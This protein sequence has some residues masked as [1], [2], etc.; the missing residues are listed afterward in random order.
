MARVRPQRHAHCGQ[1]GVMDTQ[2]EPHSRSQTEWQDSLSQ[3]VD[4]GALD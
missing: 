3:N 2:D 4:T 1:E